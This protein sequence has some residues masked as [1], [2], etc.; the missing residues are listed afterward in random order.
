MGGTFM[1]ASGYGRGDT[2]SSAEAQKVVEAT[3]A[4]P[5]RD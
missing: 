2:V 3:P 5:R 1:R 4:R